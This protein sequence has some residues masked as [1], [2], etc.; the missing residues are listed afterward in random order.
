M[1]KLV[2]L[3]LQIFLF[4]VGFAENAPTIGDIKLILNSTHSSRV[5]NLQ[6]ILLFRLVI[7]RL[8]NLAVR[9]KL[10]TLCNFVMVNAQEVS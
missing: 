3:L 2:R 9:P 10:T 4:T 5:Q 7:V 8:A 6:I 1:Y